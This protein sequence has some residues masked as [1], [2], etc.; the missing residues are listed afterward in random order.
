MTVIESVPFWS[1]L[2]GIAE[3]RW[4][5]GG[6]SATFVDAA[7]STPNRPP[8]LLVHG[9]M[10]GAWQ[11]VGLQAV[12][13]Q[14]GYAT[15]ALTYRGHHSSRP[16]ARLGRTTV[17]DYL[18]DA[19]TA[20]QHLDGKPIV[21]GQSM[22][23]LVALLLAQCDAVR[24]AVTVCSLP[25]RGIRW[26]GVRDPR[27]RWAHLPAFLAGRPIVPDRDELDDLIFNC[28]PEADRQPF[29]DL[30]VPESSLVAM[31]ISQ[32]LVPVNPRHVTC[33]VLSVSATHDRLVLSAVGADIADRYRGDHLELPGYGHYALVG[34]PGWAEAALKLV[35]WLD[36]HIE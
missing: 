36:E 26:I 23:G 18:R 4:L 6:L 34:E 25:P 30:Q 8:V 13:S 9:M 2:D 5:T 10:G 19:L 28:I 7:P 31:Q 15:C 21:I 14:H 35:R 3:S 22:G 24:A 16:V 1:R 11:F 33:P 29:F 17:Q 27:R 32:G 12:L 20:C